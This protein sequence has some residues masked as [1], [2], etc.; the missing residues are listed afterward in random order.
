[1]F[2]LLG[3][4]LDLMLRHGKLVVDARFRLCLRVVLVIVDG[5]GGGTAGSGWRGPKLRL[6]RGAG[7]GAGNAGRGTQTGEAASHFNKQTRTSVRSLELWSS[8]L[9]R[10]WRRSSWSAALARSLFLL[11]FCYVCLCC[12][13]PW[14]ITPDTATAPRHAIQIHKF[15][16]W[17]LTGSKA[18]SFGKINNNHTSRI[19]TLANTGL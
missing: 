16:C 4:E 3:K 5:V 11:C 18:L 9:D 10:G 12:C 19:R 6:C 15:T 2:E 13:F 14:M 1:M 7:R 8:S 17:P